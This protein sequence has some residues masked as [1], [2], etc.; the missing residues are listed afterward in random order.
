[1]TAGRSAV[2][3]MA[4]AVALTGCGLGP[5]ESSP[6]EATLTVTRDYG[7]E[8]VLEA[9]VSEPA[10]SETVIRFLDREA[11]DHDPV[12]RRLR[13]VDRRH[14]GRAWPAGARATGSSTSTG[15]GPPR[16]RRGRVRGGDR[17]WWDYRD[18]TD[19]LRT[20]AVVGS[21]PEPFAQRSTP[22]A[23]RLEVSVQ[24]LGGGGALRRGRPGR[25]TP[26]GSMSASQPANGSAGARRPLGPGADRPGRGPD[27]GG[28][29][30]E[31]RLRAL[32][33]Q[34]G[35]GYR[36]IALGHEAEPAL[37][38]AAEAGLVAAVRRGRGAADLGRH[39]SRRSRRPAGGARRSGRS[40]PSGTP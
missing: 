19:A 35:S 28:A 15:S 6:G 1:M 34:R 31:R 21:W 24:C 8:P 12:R 27:R 26:P 32:R 7:A 22:E 39:G 29:G 2:I 13:A 30:R 40:L 14:L 23:E 33:A 38:A 11:R 36:M 10:A 3:A 37:T 9:S 18:W 20:P 17:I 5:G 4:V 25:S 16:R